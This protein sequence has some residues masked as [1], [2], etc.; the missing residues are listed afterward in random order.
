M[1]PNRELEDLFKS[2][3]MNINYKSISVTGGRLG[4]VLVNKSDVEMIE[5]VLFALLDRPGDVIEAMKSYFTKDRSGEGKIP[6]D[7]IIIKLILQNKITDARVFKSL[8][9]LLETPVDG[10]YTATYYKKFDIEAINNA[11]R[12]WK[13]TPTK[14]RTASFYELFRETLTDIDNSYRNDVM[15]Y[16]VGDCDFAVTCS[17]DS[18]M[19]CIGEIKPMN[20]VPQLQKLFSAP[21]WAEKFGAMMRILELYGYYWTSV[22]AGLEKAAKLLTW[23]TEFFC[24]GLDYAKAFKELGCCWV[25]GDWAKEPLKNQAADDNVSMHVKTES[26]NIGCAGYPKTTTVPPKEETPGLLDEMVPEG[27]MTCLE[28]LGQKITSLGDVVDPVFNYFG[29]LPEKASE[30]FTDH[31][32][33]IPVVGIAAAVFSLV[34]GATSSKVLSAPDFATFL[35]RAQDTLKDAFFAGRGLSSVFSIFTSVTTMLKD[36]IGVSDDAQVKQLKHDLLNFTKETEALRN[37]LVAHPGRFINDPSRWGVYNEC[38]KKVFSLYE[39]LTKTDANLS[40]LTPLWQTANAG[41]RIISDNWHENVAKATTRINPVCI[42]LKGAT[43]IGKTELAK[44]LAKAIAAAVGIEPTVFVKNKSTPFWNLYNQENFVIFDDFM[45]NND[46]ARCTDDSDFMD[47]MSSNTFNVNKAAVE[48]KKTIFV[49]PFVIVCSNVATLPP[50]TCIVDVSAWERRRDVYVDVS[51]PEHEQCNPVEVPTLKP[52]KKKCTHFEGK[53]IDNFDHLLLNVRNP[54]VSGY[55]NK[56]VVANPQNPNEGYLNGVREWCEESEEFT[57]D[58]VVNAAVEK[59]KKNLANYMKHQESVRGPMANQSEVQSHNQS[60]LTV[61][62]GPPGIGKSHLMQQIGFPI[63]RT[64]AQVSE[65]LK[66]GPTEPV[67]IDD[68]TPFLCKENFIQEFV[69]FVFRTHA[70][71]EN[72]IPVVIGMNPIAFTDAFLADHDAEALDALMRRFNVYKFSFKRGLFRNSSR[73]D[74]KSGCDYTKHVVITNPSGKPILSDSLA[75][76]LRNTKIETVKTNIQTALTTYSTTEV[77]ILNHIEI[78]MTQNE[79]ISMFNNKSAASIL[80]EISRKVSITGNK[81]ISEL[82]PQMMK[83]ISSTSHS[84]GVEIQTVDEW[85][86]FGLNNGL[87]KHLDGFNARISFLDRDFCVFD[88]PQGV[89][90]GNLH[91]VQQEQVVEAADQVID[92]LQQVD[93]LAIAT[94]SGPSHSFTMWANVF[95][96]LARWGVSMFVIMNDF[97]RDSERYAKEAEQLELIDE[98]GYDNSTELARTTVFGPLVKEKA[99]PTYTIGDMMAETGEGDGGSGSGGSREKQF[100]KAVRNKGKNRSERKAAK[101]KS[102]SRDVTKISDVSET[103]VVP[104]LESQM[105][106]DPSLPPIYRKV[107]VNAVGV[108]SLK[109]GEDGKYKRLCYGL[110]IKGKFGTTVAHPFVKDQDIKVQIGALEFV[111]AVVTSVDYRTE[112]AHFTLKSNHQFSDITRHISDGS[113]MQIQDATLLLSKIDY[114]YT[115]GYAVMENRIFTGHGI[116]KTTVDGQEK[117]GILYKGE[118]GGFQHPVLTKA[119][120]CGSVLFCV[121]KNNSRKIIG[122]HTAASNTTGLA[123]L[124]LVSQ[125]TDVMKSEAIVSHDRDHSYLGEMHPGSPDFVPPIPYQPVGYI[126][127]EYGFSPDKTK[128]FRS[129]LAQEH[130][131]TEPAIL[132]KYDPRNVDQTDI[133]LEESM[134]WVNATQYDISADPLWDQAIDDVGNYLADVHYVELGRK[135]TVLTK[136]AALNGVTNLDGSSSINMSSSPG[137]GFKV[138]ADK[139]GKHS[140]IDFNPTT[141]I[142][143]INRAKPGQYLHNAIDALKRDYINEKNPVFVYMGALKDEPLRPGK[144]TRTIVGS[145]LHQLIL[146][147]QYLHTA[148]AAFSDLRHKTPVQVGINCTSLDWHNMYLD[149]RSVSDIGFDFDF[150]GWDFTIPS[151]IVAGLS[152]IY[153][154]VYKRCDPKWKPEDD[155]IRTGI[156]KG[157]SNFLFSVRTYVFQA[158]A[159]LPSGDA[160][161]AY[162][163]SLVNWLY[164]YWAWLTLCHKHGLPELACYQAFMKY[165]RIVCYGDDI[166]YAVSRDVISWFNAVTIKEV[167]ETIGLR[168]TP[169]DKSEIMQPYKKLIDCEFLSRSFKADGGYYKAPLKQTS[170]EKSCDWIRGAGS[171]YYHETPHLMSYRK[172]DVSSIAEGMLREYFQYDRDMFDERRLFFLEKFRE[173]N[174]TTTLPNY[175]DIKRDYFGSS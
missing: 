5:L 126:S 121:D 110:M 146:S 66:K 38:H 143:N 114:D 103:M 32:T 57:L 2:L 69:E 30:F 85:V 53:T 127:K 122:M 79:F 163:N 14:D 157:I 107:M 54:C 94:N 43:G 175:D 13:T 48:D 105:A 130:P 112:V 144:R 172:E 17:I 51:W 41:F 39:K 67:I 42:W 166:T 149:M 16:I 159:G 98:A 59:H 7:Y 24:E 52:G 118:L 40:S 160:G 50:N 116:M 128:L 36:L 138:G 26:V 76:H 150:K 71:Y 37:E 132:S 22:G 68:L 28:T 169:A 20:L 3:N 109:K 87:F 84:T 55:T 72:N 21:T 154:K 65:I 62:S 156:F 80:C 113:N 60:P 1:Q 117:H 90:A 23:I 12:V 4:S 140:F 74:I 86:L 58:D 44:H 77:P 173:L 47:M 124:M 99:V 111:D 104:D 18:L 152:R 161:T 35:K 100:V 139:P 91:R 119:G 61:L 142:Y 46:P 82:I 11:H 134:Q 171:H 131:K 167:L 133:L 158:K 136:T 64:Y 8:L 147:R 27:V 148:Y 83:L 165:V 102:Q 75:F 135:M 78:K 97:S 137:V 141:K 115:P 123:R 34:G 49:S 70:D 29:L 151:Q 63:V 10:Y 164:A 145:P 108:C 120:D 25:S 89:A 153:N 170:L 31:P 93:Y 162:N 6:I 106:V 174:I 73:D 168:V 81:S 56:G 92:V 19:G 101:I 45:S 15:T 155:T 125:F 33:L 9:A 95:N 96:F 129:P 88:S